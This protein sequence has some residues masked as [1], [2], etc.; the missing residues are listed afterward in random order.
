MRQVAAQHRHFDRF[1]APSTQRKGASSLRARSS[2][3]ESKISMAGSMPDLK[4]DLNPF[5]SGNP[6]T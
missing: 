1:A 6:L 3:A 4:R 2:P 5:D